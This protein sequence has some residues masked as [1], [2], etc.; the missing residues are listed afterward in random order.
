MSIMLEN[1]L[2]K[3]S[4]LYN[5][6]EFPNFQNKYFLEC[7]I[8]IANILGYSRNFEFSQSKIIHFLTYPNGLMEHVEPLWTFFIKTFNSNF[9]FEATSFLIFQLANSSEKLLL[10]FHILYFLPLIMAI[11]RCHNLYPPGRF[12][13]ILE[14]SRTFPN[15]LSPRKIF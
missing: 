13:N 4:D 12:C 6:P 8:K 1:V 14:H 15:F 11:M 7:S 9:H 10:F 5:V 3:S 2:E